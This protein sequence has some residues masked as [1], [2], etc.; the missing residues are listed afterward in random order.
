[1]PFYPSSVCIQIVSDCVAINLRFSVEFAELKPFSDV[2]LFLRASGYGGIMDRHKHENQ[3]TRASGV[4][5][6]IELA[7]QS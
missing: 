6:T 4:L 3:I 7:R 2:S 1:M 5:E